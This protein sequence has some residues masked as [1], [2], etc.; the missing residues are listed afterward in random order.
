[1]KKIKIYID[2]SVIGGLFDEEFEKYSQKL[3]EAFENNEFIPVISTIV[4]KELENAPEN[5]K[6]ALLRLKNYEILDI[7]SEVEN[8]ALKYLSEKIITE[9]YFD[10][11]LHIAIST[12]NNIDVLVSWN[13]RH[14]V[15][16]NKIHKINAVNLIENYSLLEIRSP[17]EVLNDN[18]NI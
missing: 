9:K 1:M 16:L 8:L 7:N 13:F 12:I 15:N 4:L 2:T 10:D 18:E 3:F 6:N 14:I 17:M 5:I 11:A